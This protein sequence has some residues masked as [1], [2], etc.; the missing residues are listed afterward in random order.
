MPA[1]QGSGD[2]GHYVWEGCTFDGYG[3]VT[4]GASAPGLNKTYPMAGVV[5]S[6]C[7]NRGTGVFPAAL[8]PVTK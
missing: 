8:V 5:V 1:P 3:T 7:W 6:D 4:L 2:Y